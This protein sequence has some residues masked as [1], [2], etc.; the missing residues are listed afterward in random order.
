MALALEHFMRLDAIMERA[1]N[2]EISGVFLR[3]LHCWVIF[4]VHF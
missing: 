2:S 1:H 3:P 4:F